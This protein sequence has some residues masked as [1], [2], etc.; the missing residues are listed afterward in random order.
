M[1]FPPD[2]QRV[3]V[4]ICGLTNPE[5]AL[6]AIE[7]GADALG[8]NFYPK[9][10]RALDLDRD[11]AWIRALPAGFQ[12]VAVIVN[13]TR[14]LIDRLLAA[15]AADLI[16]LHGDEDEAFC[17]ALARDGVSFVKAIRVR[18]EASLANPARFGARRSCWTPSSP[19]P[20]AA[21]DIG[22]I[23]HSPAGSSTRGA[24]DAG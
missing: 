12:K 14:D 21:R 17:A 23:G 24:A 1:T 7:L 9:S 11:A 18:D 2:S 20:S 3:Q 6:A 13:A 8:F 15:G 22:S 10:S 4:K 19:A 5:D 16:Q